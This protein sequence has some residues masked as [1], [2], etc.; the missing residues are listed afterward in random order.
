MDFIAFV[1]N[2]LNCD[3]IIT[4]HSPYLLSCV[5][6]LL[7]AHEL[8]RVRR[9]DGVQQVIPD[10]RWLSPTQVG[11]YF[12]NNGTVE[13]LLNEDAMAL[14][15]ELIDTISEQINND[16]EGLLNIER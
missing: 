10:D 5:N 7:Y 13:S 2:E 3:F 8:G 14:K 6:N 16:F 9:A 1:F 11:G 15:T 12:V 4:T